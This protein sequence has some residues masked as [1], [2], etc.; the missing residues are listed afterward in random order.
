ML[1][2]SP[3]CPVPCAGPG[4]R[5]GGL[6]ARAPEALGLTPAHPIGGLTRG[7]PRVTSVSNTADPQ[8]RPSTVTLI[9]F[10]GPS[11]MPNRWGRL[12]GAH[13]ASVR[14]LR[15]GSGLAERGGLLR[16]PPGSSG[17]VLCPRGEMKVAGLSSRPVCL[18]QTFT[19]MCPAPPGECKHRETRGAPVRP[20]QAS[21]ARPPPPPRRGGGGGGSTGSPVSSKVVWAPSRNLRVAV[22]GAKAGS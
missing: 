9:S 1:S 3:S 10:R 22:R 20:L 2:H 15:L 5:A 17:A 19:N 7:S 11:R 6:W 14:S 18:Q 8:P 13:P 4:H 16:A 21:A 12:G